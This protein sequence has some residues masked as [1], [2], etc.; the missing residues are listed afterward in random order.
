MKE[1]PRSGL[2]QDSKKISKV[3][4]GLGDIGTISTKMKRQSQ[5]VGEYFSC[6]TQGVT[7]IVQEMPDAR[8]ELYVPKLC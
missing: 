7:R 2:S 4:G 3:K 5:R 6:Q 8:P 1:E